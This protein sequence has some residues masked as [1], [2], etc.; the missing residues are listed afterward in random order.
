M[1]WTKEIIDRFMKTDPATYGHFVGVRFMKP[2][3]KPINKHS[4]MIG[5]ALYG[6]DPGKR[7][8]RYV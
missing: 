4:K 8:M 7:F 1:D 5:P 2:E 6:Q 3:I